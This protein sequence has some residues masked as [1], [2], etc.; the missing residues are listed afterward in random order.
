MNRDVSSFVIQRVWVL[1]LL[2]LLFLCRVL[3][4]LGVYLGLF[5]FLPP[6]DQWQSGTLSY[7][8]LLFSQ[9]IILAVMLFI[10]RRLLTKGRLLALATARPLKV[11][12]R[13][14]A[15]LY[16][17]VMLVRLLVWWWGELNDFPFFGVW[18]PPV[19]HLVLAAYLLTITTVLSPINPESTTES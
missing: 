15:T 18:I 19:F 17:A 8:V 9:I 5:P 7:P 11:I 14:F 3:G 6:M 4:Q 13:T 10:R 16:A 12:V 2:A 1:D